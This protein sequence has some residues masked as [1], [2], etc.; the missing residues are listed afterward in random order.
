MFELIKKILVM[1]SLSGVNSLKCVSMKNQECKVREIV[2]DNEYML[3]PYSI[4]VSRRNG[5]CKDISNPYSKVCFPVVIKNITA[6]VFDLILWT[7]KTKQ[8]K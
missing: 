2:V 7:N 4:K 3:Y 6:K 5:N 1:S 8:K